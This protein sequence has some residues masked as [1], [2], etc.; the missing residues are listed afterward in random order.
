MVGRNGDVG[1]T[2]FSVCG[3]CRHPVPLVNLGLP[4]HDRLGSRNIQTMPALIWQQS[5]HTVADAFP[6]IGADIT[7]VRQLAE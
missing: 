7:A 2:T 4:G 5:S 1:K 3:L 6:K